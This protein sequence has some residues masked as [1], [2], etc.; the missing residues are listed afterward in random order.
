V[1]AQANYQDQQQLIIV[2]VSV[3]DT[4]WHN[5]KKKEIFK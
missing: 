5:G 1:T 3:Q 2:K 4:Y